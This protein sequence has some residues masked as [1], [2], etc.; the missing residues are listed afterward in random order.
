MRV[1]AFVPFAIALVV[2]WAVFPASGGLAQ[3]TPTSVA[4]PFNPCDPSYN[5]TAEYQKLEGCGT[6][7]PAAGG[8]YTRQ[9]MQMQLRQAGMQGAINGFVGA[10]QRSAANAATARQQQQ[11]FQAEMARRQQEAEQQR[12]LAEQQRIDAM[13]ARLNSELKLSGLPF[14]LAMK[15]V[16]VPGPQDLHMKGMDIPG[17][18]D[19]KM[20]FGDDGATSTS[21]G[22]KGLPGIY[23]G[24]PAGGA[25][26]NT[27]DA[28][29]NGGAA[30]DAPASNPNLASGPG[31]GTTGPGIPGL[32]GIFLDGAQPNQ[33]PQLA[34]A[35]QNL[36]AGPERDITEDTALHAALHNPALTAP[37]QDPQVTSF[38]KDDLNYQQALQDTT[39]A[40]QQYSAAQ[41]QVVA[42]QSAVATAKAQLAALQPTVEQ[43]AALTHMLDVA[44]TDE[45]ASEAARQ[46]F[47][48]SNVHLSVARTQAAGTLAGLPQDSSASPIHLSGNTASAL[49]RPTTAGIAPGHPIASPPRVSVPANPGE[50]NPARSLSPAT[51]RLCAQLSGAQ[52]ALRRLLATQTMHNEDRAVW[53]KSVNDASGDAWKLAYEMANEYAGK[54]LTDE[55]KALIHGSDEGSEERTELEEALERAERARKLA[56]TATDKM[57][58]ISDMVHPSEETEDWV[59]NGEEMVKNILK[60][61]DMQE[62]L[63]VSSAGHEYIEYASL[64]LD[65]SYDTLAEVLSAQ[66]IK[67]L[68]QN[69][70]QF[71]LAQKALQR[72]I[73]A[74]VA[75]LK[76][77]RQTAPPGEAGCSAYI[78]QQ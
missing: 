57:D 36:P 77:A 73:Q 1:R 5:Y 4:V 8:A 65:S 49:L 22:L 10:M 54:K 47:E 56:E 21:Y 62:A 46:I 66:R 25:T 26:T 27:A 17:P 38:Q 19:M 67:Q 74:T 76:I 68:N 16:D 34:Q 7:A 61:E 11:A 20:K 23:V 59:E 33:S 75:K 70:D 39:A 78:S 51:A 53:D 12:R 45:D 72:R 37:T 60:N 35:A 2:A 63:Q 24:G 40:Y 31:T 15:D 43:Q 30:S 48:N 50:R 13:F 55:L 28:T 32:P 71:L 44:K 64:I 3:S 9:N 69:E 52:D 14:Q 58:S 41:N 29:A 6:S 42:D 18:G